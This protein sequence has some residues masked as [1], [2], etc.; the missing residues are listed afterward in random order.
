MIEEKIVINGFEEFRDK[1]IDNLVILFDVILFSLMYM[2]ISTHEISNWSFFCDITIFL[3]VRIFYY[4]PF[5]YFRFKNIP[6]EK[7]ANYF[8]LPKLFCFSIYIYLMFIEPI[9]L[10]DF[11]MNYIV[12]LSICTL[13]IYAIIYKT[14]KENSKF[15]LLNK[16]LTV[17]FMMSFSF[18]LNSNE[19]EDI[20]SHLFGI[21]TEDFKN[22]FN[23]NISL[24]ISIIVLFIITIPYN[25]DELIEQHGKKINFIIS[26]TTIIIL[27][28][29]ILLNIEE[30]S[31]DFGII[32]FYLVMMLTT[33]ISINLIT[34]LNISKYSLI[35]TI[36]FKLL[37]IFYV[38][39]SSYQF[40][41]NIVI[42]VAL[43]FVF[44]FFIFKIPNLFNVKLTLFTITILAISFLYTVTKDTEFNKT[45]ASLITVVGYLITLSFIRTDNKKK[46][47]KSTKIIKEIINLNLSDKVHKSLRKSYE[48]VHKRKNFLPH[49][50]IAVILILMLLGQI[51]L[52]YYYYDFIQ[53]TNAELDKQLGVEQNPLMLYIIYENP[54]SKSIIDV[55]TSLT[56][57][58]IMS[59]LILFLGVI[60]SVIYITKDRVII[61]SIFGLKY[62]TYE[63]DEL[64][65]KNEGAKNKL[66][67]ESNYLFTIEEGNEKD[68]VSLYNYIKT[69]IDEKRP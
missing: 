48:K 14:N 56:F 13:L 18:F 15:Y 55:I 27:T 9:K 49:K 59:C 11:I 2:Y 5:Y 19:F 64:I 40:I 44:N 39:N 60:S 33:I 30:R 69:R 3:F 26:L 10:N 52:H 62:Y 57:K 38:I 6:K 61:V 32:T 28:Y 4:V 47:I 25:S 8:M 35:M 63:Y 51:F 1:T 23:M 58:L 29:Y 16:L 68:D 53:P 42:A 31:I 67:F 37:I 43:F 50:R 41:P 22:T 54:I 46:K 45:I 17:V 21:N 66:Y 20:K 36:I 7:I 24:Y 34:F 65:I 12:F